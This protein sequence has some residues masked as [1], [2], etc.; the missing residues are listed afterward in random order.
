MK[1]VKALA[2][3]IKAWWGRFSAKTVTITVVLDRWGTATIAEQR[4]E[5]VNCRSE[6]AIH[7]IHVE[8]PY[9]VSNSSI[10]GAIVLERVEIRQAGSHTFHEYAKTP[11]SLADTLAFCE[12]EMQKYFPTMPAKIWVKE[13]KE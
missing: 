5:T 12:S 1:K 7:G 9:L 8:V 2:K 6:Y 11:R 3:S 13:V 4:V 10:S